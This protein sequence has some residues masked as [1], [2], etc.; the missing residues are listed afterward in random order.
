M[1]NLPSP[2]LQVLA[3]RGD[4]LG[5]FIVDLVLISIILIVGAFLLPSSITDSKGYVHLV[6]YF[7]YFPLFTMSYQA[8][9][10]KMMLNLRVVDNGGRKLSVGKVWLRECLGK[11]LSPLCIGHVW[12]LF[13]KDHKNAWDYLAGT[14]VIV[15]PRLVRAPAAAQ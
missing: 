12:I 6:A 15:L 3:S 7:I 5:A 10:G 1:E 14:R 8:S 2:E 4:R 13:N 9:P 11:W